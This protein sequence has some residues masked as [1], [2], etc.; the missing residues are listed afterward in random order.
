VTGPPGLSDDRGDDL[1]LADLIHPLP[2][3]QQLLAQA[4][5][6]AVSGCLAGTPAAPAG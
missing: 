4:L 6:R 1:L 2:A 5:L 3:G